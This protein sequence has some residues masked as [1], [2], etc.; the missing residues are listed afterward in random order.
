MNVKIRGLEAAATSLVFVLDRL[1]TDERGFRLLYPGEGVHIHRP[2]P[3]PKTGAVPVVIRPIGWPTESLI[4]AQFIHSVT[5]WVF[6]AHGHI[7]APH[8]KNICDGITFSPIK[9]GLGIEL[10]IPEEERYA[11]VLANIERIIRVLRKTL[12]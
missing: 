2:E 3:V 5:G 4:E 10:H 12:K 8:L 6:C 7:V 11:V 9:S 1:I